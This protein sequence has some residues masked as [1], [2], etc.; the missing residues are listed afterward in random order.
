MEAISNPTADTAG[1]VPF[2]AASKIGEI[3]AKV[4]SNRGGARAGAGRK[5][6][7]SSAPMEKNSTQPTDQNQTVVTEADLEFVR[8]TA[9]AALGLL[10]AF[11]TNRVY[12]G[13]VS[14]DIQLK[15]EAEK[16]REQVELEEEEIEMVAK[17]CKAVAAKYT[18]LA[19]YAPEM[20]LA[21]WAAK[22]SM[23]VMG[24]MREIKQLRIAVI[25]MKG[26]GVRNA[27]SP[28]AQQNIN[29]GQVGLG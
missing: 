11:V 24:V 17:S 20:L 23:T 7:F 4:K 15:P 18:F 1:T 25:A 6:G 9:K 14:I 22:Y 16:F 5:S 12:N 21:G 10:D 29:T 19:A 26:P 13:V 28:Q 2:S 8:E 3:T 27:D